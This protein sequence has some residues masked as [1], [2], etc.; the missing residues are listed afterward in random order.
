MVMWL[1][2][3]LPLLV[4]FGV[5]LYVYWMILTD[6][7]PKPKGPCRYEAHRS[8]RNPRHA[9]RRSDSAGTNFRQNP[10]DSR[11]KADETQEEARKVSA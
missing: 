7:A 1:V 5:T 2:V 9:V 11:Q 6:S 4:V 10:G 8:S 3:W